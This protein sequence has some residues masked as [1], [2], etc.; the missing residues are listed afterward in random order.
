MK[1]NAVDLAK[2]ISKKSWYDFDECKELFEIADMN[3]MWQNLI[4]EGIVPA[5]I[6][7]KTAFSTWFNGTEEKP[8]ERTEFFKLWQNGQIG[9]VDFD[10]ETFEDAL[11]RAADALGLKL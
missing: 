7:N 5:E 2:S 10:C 11:F 9:G 8:V 1:K 6:P 4:D 3:D